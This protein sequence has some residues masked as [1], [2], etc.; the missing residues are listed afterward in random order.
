[1]R[2]LWLL[3][4]FSP[5]LRICHILAIIL[6]F[7]FPPLSAGFPHLLPLSASFIYISTNS[8]A[9]RP[10]ALNT[11][12]QYRIRAVLWV[13]KRERIADEDTY[14]PTAQ[15]TACFADIDFSKCMQSKHRIE[16]WWRECVCVCQHR[17]PS[18]WNDI[19]LI[20]SHTNRSAIK[21]DWGTGRRR[22]GGLKVSGKRQSEHEW[23]KTSF[24]VKMEM[25]K[26]NC[27]LNRDPRRG[28]Q[29]EGSQW[30]DLLMMECFN[31][32]FYKTHI[33]SPYRIIRV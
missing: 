12:S 6:C 17:A 28:E 20:Y 8:I 22:T 14:T 21:C 29:E 2:A 24:S 5:F 27:E 18:K 19:L 23:G 16:G 26:A 9:E 4:G 3:V 7:S 30:V 13:Q 33:K 15:H 1:M 25:E 11:Q 32:T 31:T 10:A